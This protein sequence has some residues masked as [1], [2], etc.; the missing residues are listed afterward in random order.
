MTESIPVSEKYILTLEEAAAY[1]HIGIGKLRKLVAANSKAD[2]VLW[3]A[4]H[5][6]I[7]RK[8]FESY[9]DSVNSI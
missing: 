9:I 8:K 2:W 4:S 3:N 1:F 7:K 6:R 5:V